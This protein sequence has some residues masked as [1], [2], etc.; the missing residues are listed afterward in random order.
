MDLG[1]VFVS[2][3]L[4]I[5]S[6][7][8]NATCSKKVELQNAR[9]GWVRTLIR[10]LRNANIF[11]IILRHKISRYATWWYIFSI[12]IL[13]QSVP[14]VQKN[15]QFGAPHEICSLLTF[16]RC[17]YRPKTWNLNLGQKVNRMTP[18]HKEIEQESKPFFFVGNFVSGRVAGWGQ[19]DHRNFIL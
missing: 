14:S 17:Q 15:V 4:P 7:L 5:P 12:C 11:N 6:L 1:P 3:N 9:P 2:H 19:G 13:Y 10:T 8:L 16:C 18:S